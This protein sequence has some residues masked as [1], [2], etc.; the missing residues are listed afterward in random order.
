MRLFIDSRLAG[1]TLT[2][3]MALRLG[4]GATKAFALAA[5][6]FNPRYTPPPSFPAMRRLALSLG[7][8]ENPRLRLECY[9]ALTSNTIQFGARAEVSAKVQTA[10][11]EFGAAA[12]IF[13]DALIELDP[14]GFIVD[15][16]ALVEVT[17][18]G[19][20]LIQAQL[21]ATLSGT[22]P[23]HAVGFA[24]VMFLGRHRIPFEVRVGD[25]E[26]V[27]LPTLN[28]LVELTKE[29]AR[30]ESWSTVPPVD[31]ADV[32]VLRD[33]SAGASGLLHPMGT[34]ALR[35]RLIPFGKRIARFGSAV[36]EG[37]ALKF[38]LHEILVGGR[39]DAVSPL[40]DDFAPGQ[41]EELTEDEKLSRPTFERMQAGGAGTASVH[42][43]SSR[44][45]WTNNP[46]YASVD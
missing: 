13:F 17:L 29:I 32:V 10:I 42:A 24:E 4:W 28:L 8:S 20:P 1:F 37:G 6:G 23:W 7:S 22:K 11:G 30:P 19:R 39:V 16:G 5:G 18:S 35:Q 46:G 34:V 41:Y 15:L 33:S 14:F 26:P 9:L 36:P 40:L 25:E 43:A 44:W 45:G 38:D 2:G 27:A 31:A 21:M 3:D 12:M